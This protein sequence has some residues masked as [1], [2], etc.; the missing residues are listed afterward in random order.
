M[1]TTAPSKPFYA[2]KTFWL[3]SIAL[4]AMM[5]PA[6]QS[7]LASNPVE[8]VAA[9]AAVNVLLRFVTSGKI[10]LG[11][12]TKGSVGGGG[13]SALAALLGCAGLG[14]C[15]FSLTSCSLLPAGT[16]ASIYYLDS[17]TGAKAGLRLKDG[18]GSGTLFVPVY[19]GDGKEAGRANLE[20]PIRATK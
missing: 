12:D 19:D 9:L 17:N 6:A 4:I 16:T 3:N 2:S 1:D 14:V 10:S 20:V 18:A 15:G 13:A 8:A 11:W 7:W 5:F